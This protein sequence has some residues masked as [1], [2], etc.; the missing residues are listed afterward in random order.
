LL[1]QEKVV[2]VPGSAFGPY[3]DEFVRLA[4]PL[5]KDKINEAC[6]RIEKFLSKN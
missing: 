4:Y 5:K 1:N 3:S 6:D 2:T